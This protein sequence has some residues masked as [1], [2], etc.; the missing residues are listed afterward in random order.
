MISNTGVLE[1]VG[2]HRLVSACLTVKP[3]VIGDGCVFMLGDREWSL[4]G[5]KMEEPVDKWL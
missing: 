5:E 1:S 2:N 3:W 4:H